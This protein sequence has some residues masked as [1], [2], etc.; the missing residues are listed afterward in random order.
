MSNIIMTR[1]QYDALLAAAHAGNTIEVDRLRDLIDEANGIV[2]YKLWIRWQDVGGRPPPRIELGKGW[3]SNQTYFLE[4]ERK[5]T[6]LDVDD[7]LRNNA[8]NPVSVMVTP[9][10]NATVG[11]TLINDY[12]FAN[13][14]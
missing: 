7:A 2:R 14:G 11:W 5:I 12:D 1:A 3:P 10:P 8:K 13:G 6:R 4:L 9:D